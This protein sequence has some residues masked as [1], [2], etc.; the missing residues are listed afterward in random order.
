MTFACHATCK[1]Q[2]SPLLLQP[3]LQRLLSFLE[4]SCRLPLAEIELASEIGKWPPHYGGL[5]LASTYNQPKESSPKNIFHQ[6][7]FW[8]PERLHEAS[9]TLPLPARRPGAAL[10][11]SSPRPR[12]SQGHVDVNF[13]GSPTLWG[14][15][16]TNHCCG[17]TL[18][19]I[20]IIRSNL[21]CTGHLLLAKLSLSPVKP[22][23][24]RM[25]IVA[26]LT[27]LVHSERQDGGRRPVEIFKARSTSKT[28]ARSPS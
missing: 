3:I 6:S 24:P 12:E 2:A 14:A 11:V 27:R 13:N 7:G 8:L 22:S 5:P 1:T 21:S 25:L 20:A 17:S 16:S 28:C 19:F 26:P 9:L 23:L 15:I 18:K 4:L 10:T